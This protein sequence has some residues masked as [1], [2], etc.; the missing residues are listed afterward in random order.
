[1]KVTDC[2]KLLN[3]RWLNLFQADWENDKGQTGSWI[4]TS[5]KDKPFTES[6]RADAVVVVPFLNNKMVLIRQ[7][8]CPLNGYI[9]EHP[10]GV[11]DGNLS[12]LEL[13]GKELKEETGLSIGK[14]VIYPQTLYNTPGITDENV[15]YV[16][17]EAHG[18]PTTEF[19][20]KSEDITI[21]LM[22]RKYAQSKLADPNI[23]FSA[24]CW[25][26]TMAWANGHD[27]I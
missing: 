12:V 23:R 13:A 1:M 19:N 25:L 6:K 11:N 5:R 24:K 14:H 10:A 8:R 18:T 2:K 16:F 7:F 27:W 17:T 22:D 20:E 21:H 3:T 4:F 26:V 15:S 9:F